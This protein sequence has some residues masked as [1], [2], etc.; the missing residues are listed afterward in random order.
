[1]Q[2]RD[3]RKK[4]Q[5]RPQDGGTTSSTNGEDLQIDTGDTQ[6]VLDSIDR[7]LEATRNAEAVKQREQEERQRSRRGSCGC[8]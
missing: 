6:D 4:H 1:M 3:S 2:Q 7:A 5:R 8:F